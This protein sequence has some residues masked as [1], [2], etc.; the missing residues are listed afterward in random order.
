MFSK[1]SSFVSDT[2]HHKSGSVEAAAEL[3]A[4][5]HHGTAVID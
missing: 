5:N 3:T 4:A 2:R 1:N